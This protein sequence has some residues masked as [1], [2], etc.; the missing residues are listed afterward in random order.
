MIEADLSSEVIDPFSLM[1]AKVG[2]HW[3]QVP[4]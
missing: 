3:V 4:A 1:P 2:V